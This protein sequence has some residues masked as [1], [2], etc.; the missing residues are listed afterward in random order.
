MNKKQKKILSLGERERRRGKALMKGS[1]MS[2]FWRPKIQHDDY[3]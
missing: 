2:K 3:S 1:K